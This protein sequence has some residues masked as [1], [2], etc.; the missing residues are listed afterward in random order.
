MS[1]ESGQEKSEDPTDKKKE[2]SKKK[3]QSLRSKDLSTAIVVLSAFLLFYVFSSSIIEKVRFVFSMSFS[4]SR[5]EIYNPVLMLKM[6]GTIFTTIFYEFIPFMTLMVLAS[7]V[8]SVLMGGIHFSAESLMFKLERMNPIKGL[9]KMFSLK[10]IVELVKSVLKFV[11]IIS[12]F[13]LALNTYKD[14]LY[15]LQSY[16][17]L[18]GIAD[19]MNDLFSM[20]IIISMSLFIVSMVDVPFQIFDHIK[21]LKM[22]KQEVKDES[23]DQEGKPE[24]KG[25]IRKKQQELKNKRMMND[26]PKAD[27]IITNPTHYAIAIKYDQ[28]DGKAP[29]VVAKGLDNIALMINKVAKAHNVTFVEAP[30]LARS[31]YYHV[32]IGGEIPG[33]LYV[34]VAQ[35]LAY[36]YELEMFKSGKSKY[37][38][39]PYKYEIPDELQRK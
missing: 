33:G 27:V 11:L 1:E 9:Q 4:A 30:P 13:A 35:V 10:S 21:K 25:Q 39:K 23:K 7:L 26:V 38:N 8:G 29:I 17:Y 15:L 22:T 32:D 24:V 12:L 5:E 28:D 37:P 20:L 31:L 16:G 3:G 19:G 18:Q 14:D 6:V 2:D 34:A 36:V